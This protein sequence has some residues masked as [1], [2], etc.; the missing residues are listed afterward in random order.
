MKSC[1]AKAT[2]AA[3]LIGLLAPHTLFPRLGGFQ[4]RKPSPLAHGK[5]KND[6]PKQEAPTHEQQSHGLEAAAQ[7]LDEHN[8]AQEEEC[9]HTQYHAQNN[10]HEQYQEHNHVAYH[11]APSTHYNHEVNVED[12]ATYL[13]MKNKHLHDRLTRMEQKLHALR[14]ENH[15]LRSSIHT[16]HKQRQRLAS[17]LAATLNEKDIP[18]PRSYA[19][20]S[21]RNAPRQRTLRG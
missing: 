18:R 10:E 17:Q 16:L 6:P 15:K 4:Y 2:L 8:V 14:D 3:L 9:E 5:K 13:E 20:R 11:D 12:H 7:M 21:R 19:Y 1:V